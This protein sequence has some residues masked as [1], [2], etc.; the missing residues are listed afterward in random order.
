MKCNKK[1]FTKFE[2]MLY[3]V[4]SD[5]RNKRNKGRTKRKECRYYYCKHCNAYHLTSM[6][7]NTYKLM[8][9]EERN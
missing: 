4:N 2:A 8:N 7:S 6:D 1:K 9:N 3:L 5:Y